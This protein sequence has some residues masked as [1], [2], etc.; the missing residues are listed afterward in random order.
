MIS[1]A[2]AW[3]I[4]AAHVRPLDAERVALRR[5]AGRTLAEDIAAE[6]DQPPF[7]RVTM[8]GIAVRYREAIR[9]YRL[10][11][12]QFAGEA[13]LELHDERHCIEIMT[14]AVMPAGCDTVVPV[15]R[16]EKRDHGDG[17]TIRL[18]D[19]YRPERGQFVHARGSDHRAGARLL[20]RGQAVGGP[21][22]AVLASA[23]A[24]EVRVARLPRIAI[25]A[26]GNE[27]VEAGAPIQPHQVR[28]SNGPA[29][30]AA[31]SRHALGDAALHHLPDEPAVLE[32]RIGAL[33]AAS[34]ALILSGGVSR[35]K[36][37]YVPGI[38]ESLGV[39]KH[40]H[41]VAQRPGKP[42][43]FGTDDAGR[44]VFALPGNPVSTLVCFTR[45]VLPALRLASGA[46]ARAGEIAVLSDD[47]RF[48]PA[49]TAFV[50]VTLSSAPDGRL[51]AAPRRTNTS[52]DF[53]ALAGTDGFVELA[54][55]AQQFPAGTP[56][57]LFRW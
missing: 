51:L 8:D 7:D 16:I 29:L 15:E 22:M 32:G 37:D 36:A 13:A 42:F 47:W 24:S 38:L 57:A 43:W 45:Y 39:R 26:T 48:E 19:D 56:A 55:D 23:G 2:E 28:L 14:G 18:A 3:D 9:D 35:G 41:R 31:L 33:L 5:A 52:G 1:V 6:R 17:A 27:L 40:F 46:S 20:T 11:A 54:A 21:E 12:T 44:M 4:V 30:A 34:D 10:Q 25:V 49:L 53:T 50:P